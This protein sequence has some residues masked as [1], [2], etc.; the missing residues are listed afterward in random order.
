MRGW[1]A[2]VRLDAGRLLAL[3]HEALAAAALWGR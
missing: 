1:D 2:D 3:V